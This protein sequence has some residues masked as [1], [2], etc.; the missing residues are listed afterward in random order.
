[1]KRGTEKLAAMGMKIS[2]KSFAGFNHHTQKIECKLEGVNDEWKFRLNSTLKLLGINNGQ[3]EMLAY[4]KLLWEVRAVPNIPAYAQLPESLLAPLRDARDYLAGVF[5]EKNATTMNKMISA[6]NSAQ[7]TL[8][9]VSNCLRF[10]FLNF[11]TTASS[12]R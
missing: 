1:M 12:T 4:E 2:E 11:L 7:K 8:L 5:Q 3:V 10:A 9:K 6:A